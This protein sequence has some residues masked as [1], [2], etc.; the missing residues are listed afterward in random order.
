MRPIKFRAKDF[1]GLWHYGFVVMNNTMAILHPSF[2]D[3]TALAGVSIYVDPETVGQ[4]TGLYDKNGAEIYEGDILRYDDQ[5]MT[6]TYE[7]PEFTF[8][9]NEYYLHYLT[10]PELLEVVGNIHDRKEARQHELQ[11]V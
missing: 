10:A 8:A 2:K 4:F 3:G 7:A 6:V 11:S 1:A 9:N 5:Y